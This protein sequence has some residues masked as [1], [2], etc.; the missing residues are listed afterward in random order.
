MGCCLLP[1][2]QKTCDMGSD[3]WVYCIAFLDDPYMDFTVELFNNV[4]LFLC[5][6]FVADS[7]QSADHRV[8]DGASSAHHRVCQRVRLERKGG[9][10]AGQ[11]E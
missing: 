9:R 11:G 6:A 2:A 5:F 4:L 10:M 8:G 7:S 3:Y 1:S